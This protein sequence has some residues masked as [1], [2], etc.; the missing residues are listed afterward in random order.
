MGT[1]DPEGTD[2]HAVQP[3]HS[4]T[5]YVL[6]GSPEVQHAH[7]GQSGESVAIAEQ[8]QGTNEGAERLMRGVM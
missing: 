4:L 3:P 5:R 1:C 6:P 2:A 8:R 7:V